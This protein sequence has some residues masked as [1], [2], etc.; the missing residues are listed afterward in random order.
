MEKRDWSNNEKRLRELS[1]YPLFFAYLCKMGEAFLSSELTYMDDHGGGNDPRSISS[2]IVC[3]MVAKGPLDRI[4][5]R[6]AFITPFFPN[7][8]CQTLNALYFTHNENMPRLSMSAM[9][10]IYARD[11]NKDKAHNEGSFNCF[12]LPIDSFI[13]ITCKK[14]L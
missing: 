5:E 10:L 3:Q 1:V 9:G 14:K 8:T 11:I 2:I 13:E 7:S 4:E 6:Y 12:V